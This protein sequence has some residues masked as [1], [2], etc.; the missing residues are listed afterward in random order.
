MVSSILI[1]FILVPALRLNTPL[2][3]S[4]T[5]TFVIWFVRLTGTGFIF[6]FQKCDLH[7][8]CVIISILEMAFALNFD[9]V[10]VADLPSTSK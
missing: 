7:Y 6:V 5:V 4:L 3:H 1:I 8:A 2:G 9:V 10:T